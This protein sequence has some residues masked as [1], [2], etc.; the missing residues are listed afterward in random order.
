M[1]K[2]DVHIVAR[3]EG[4]R[5]TI[6]LG[7]LILA[8]ITVSVGF[9]AAS[10]APFVLIS[11]LVFTAAIIWFGDALRR[12][13]ARKVIFDGTQLIDDSGAVLCTLDEIVEVERGM[14]LFK[15]SNGFALRLNAD[16][17]RGWSPGLWWRTGRRVGVGGATPGRGSRNMADA[18]TAA[19]ALRAMPDQSKGS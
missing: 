5:W 8:T 19:L 3:P 9:R 11:T 15:P 17:P 2:D 7:L 1:S 12:T 6:L 18:I 4:L 14:S 13:P 16:R 10:D